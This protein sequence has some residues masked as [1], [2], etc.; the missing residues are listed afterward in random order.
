M[1]DC[2]VG[3]RWAGD[4]AVVSCVR[5]KGGDDAPNIGHTIERADRDV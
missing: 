2:R 5:C 1:V 4:M 3:Q